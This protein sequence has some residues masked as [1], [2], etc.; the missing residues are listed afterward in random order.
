MDHMIWTMWISLL[1]FTGQNCDDAGQLNSSTLIT[2]SNMKLSLEYQLNNQSVIQGEQITLHCIPESNT[3]LLIWYFTPMINRKKMKKTVW[4]EKL[5]SSISI[6]HDS[7]MH[8]SMM[9]E[10]FDETIE[11]GVC[12]PY[13]TCKEQI[14]M[15][16]IHVYPSGVLT[17]TNAQSYH[18]GNYQCAM[19]TGVKTITMRRYLIVQVPPNKPSIEIT[20]F[21][22]NDNLYNVKRNLQK[23]KYYLEGEYLNLTCQSSGGLPSP[24]II[25]SFLPI[26][27][28]TTVP[29]I[30]SASSQDISMKVEN[31]FYKSEAVNSTIIYL[32]THTPY[33]VTISQI[34]LKL[35]FSH[36]GMNV[37][38]KAVNNIASSMSEP[39]EINV[40]YAPV[41]SKFFQEPWIVLYEEESFISCQATGNPPPI[42][43][44]IDQ[45]RRRI[46]KTDRLN[47]AVLTESLF[48]G[49]VNRFS[50]DNWRINVSCYANNIMGSSEKLLPIEFYFAPIVTTNEIVYA[51]I[52]ESIQL[53]C[54]A[55]S[56]PPPINVFWYRKINHKSL[57]NLQFNPNTEKLFK[58]TNNLYNYT[59]NYT[60]NNHR[61]YWSSPILQI[62]TV[63]IDDAGVYV[64]AAENTIHMRDH[65][66]SSYRRESESHLF[67]FYPPGK[68]TIKKISPGGKTNENLSIKLQCVQNIRLGLPTPSVKWLWI[69]HSCRTMKSVELNSLT[70]NEVKRK[71]SQYTDQIVISLTD[72]HIDGLY[73]CEVEN[74]VGH[75]MSDPINI[76]LNE[77]PEIIEGPNIDHIWNPSFNSH[78]YPRLRCIAH[79][80]P[81]P[82]ITW[83]HNGDMI[84]STTVKNSNNFSCSW[85]KIFTSVKCIELATGLYT[86]ETTSELIWGLDHSSFSFNM[87]E[88]S[89]KTSQTNNLT[90]ICQSF[91][92]MNEGIYTCQA[93]NEYGQ[94]E[95]SPANMILK[96]PPILIHKNLL[97]YSLNS[98][99]VIN[100]KHS[101]TSS[102][103]Q[104][105]ENI[106]Q[107]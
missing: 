22:S 46:S 12:K 20:S 27:N 92:I 98:M 55:I 36:D 63:T 100:T 96:Y 64:C 107:I 59:N 74:E 79:G 69:P 5:P 93:M 81:A 38:C 99:E 84:Y 83:I 85:K 95:S 94:E 61:I 106:L 30:S 2:S 49:E 75:S 78:S 32:P 15:P 42:V 9:N 3:N 14:Q 65:Q 23:R 57:T 33:G 60:I 67:V 24:Q 56:N 68:P 37:Q 41:I 44:W 103:K 52:G 62:N 82:Q 6:I 31:S 43:Y 89:E 88:N 66:L 87:E 1:V 10:T 29:L 77:S 19:L 50:K 105:K 17:V 45:H 40:Q 86:W 58:V 70:P 76:T 28:K 7:Y 26:Q 54:E 34:T 91:N 18:S 101:L 25:W 102:V 47:S 8:I 104:Q 71:S 72:S 80:K 13:M 51:R 39:Y 21:N 48:K 16:G 11:F 4:N 73:Y 90:S 97:K 53:L 35:S